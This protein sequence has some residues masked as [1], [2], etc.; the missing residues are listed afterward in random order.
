[1]ERI[2]ALTIAG[3]CGGFTSTVSWFSGLFSQADIGEPTNLLG[4]AG[5][6][7]VVTIVMYKIIRL[8]TEMIGKSIIEKIEDGNKK[9]LESNK[10]IDR[11][12]ENLL[13]SVEELTTDKS[14]T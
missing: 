13:S 12:I 8:I 11:K 7:V 10:E 3:L 14:I 9:I 6:T 5:V 4:K 1:M 2:Y